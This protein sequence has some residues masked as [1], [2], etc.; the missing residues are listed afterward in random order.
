MPAY[1]LAS[2]DLKNLPLLRHVARI[3]K[4]IIISTGGAQLDDIHR[5]MDAIGTINPRVGI[6]QCTADLSRPSPS[7]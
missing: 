3:G 2:G 1:K 5:A 7:R 6:L 4:P